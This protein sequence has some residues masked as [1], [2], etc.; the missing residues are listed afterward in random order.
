M[1]SHAS[2]VPPLP[3]L[4]RGLGIRSIPLDAREVAVDAAFLRHIIAQLVAAAPFDPEFYKAAYPDAQAEVDAGDFPSLH[5]HFLAK[6]YLNGHLPA[7]L[8]FDPD[9]YLAQNPGLSKIRERLGDAGLLK[10][11]TDA[12]H[13]EGRSGSPSDVENKKWAVAADKSSRLVRRDALGTLT[14]EPAKLQARP[15]RGPAGVIL[16]GPVLGLSPLENALR[17]KRHGRIDDALDDAARYP[18]RLAGEWNYLGLKFYHFGHTMAETVH[19]ILPTQM[20]VNCKRWVYLDPNPRPVRALSEP[21]Y[22]YEVLQYFD[23]DPQ[24]V[25]IVGQNTLVDRLNIAEQGSHLGAVPDEAYLTDLAVFSSRRL[26]ELAP[27]VKRS[28]L[29]YVSRSGLPPGGNYLGEKFIE[30]MLEKNGFSIFHP[31]KHSLLEQMETYHQ[32]KTVIF[33]EGSACHG[34]ELLGYRMLQ[35]SILIPRRFN[36]LNTFKNILQSR[37][38]EFGMFRDFTDLGSA[39]VSSGSGTI[40]QTWSVSIIKIG[41]LVDFLNQS[42]GLCLPKVDNANYKDAIDQDFEEYSAHYNNPPHMV[43]RDI[44]SAMRKRYLDFV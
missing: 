22:F 12:G 31:E 19:R 37:S 1:P 11:F 41:S 13:A 39:V 35:K 42:A 30:S 25:L 8:Q 15:G 26:S 17:H 38:I 36:Q 27:R 34:V 6:G 14:L 7:A 21:A 10:H 29:V 43:D 18:H 16:S 28:P 40:V 23:I 33:G 9:W 20:R 4:M 5:A 3:I 44:L 24:N 2:G 32:A